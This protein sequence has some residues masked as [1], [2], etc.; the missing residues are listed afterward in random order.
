MASRVRSKQCCGQKWLL[1]LSPVLLL[2]VTISVLTMTLPTP[3][4]PADTDRRSSRA[5]S[6]AEDFPSRHW[7][8]ALH[9]VA[10]FQRSLTRINHGTW[11]P[12]AQ[13]DMSKHSVAHEPFGDAAASD[14]MSSRK[15]SPTDPHKSKHSS[16]ETASK[17]KRKGVSIQNPTSHHNPDPLE[18]TVKRNGPRHRIKPSNHSSVVKHT[19]QTYIHLERRKSTAG[20]SRALAHSSV[21]NRQP[22]DR[23]MDRWEQRDTIMHANT[24]IHDKETSVKSA[25]NHRDW[26]KHRQQS[27]LSDRKNKGQHAVKNPSRGLTKSDFPKDPPKVSRPRKASFKPVGVPKKDDSEQCLSYTAQDFLDSD[28]RRIRTG[29]DLQHTPWFSHD[30]IQKMVLLSEGE[31]ASK[32]KVPAH[33]QVLQLALN[34]P[35]HQQLPVK[36]TSQRGLDP[37]HPETHSELCQQ[38]RC[39]LIKRSEDWF[40]VFAYHLDRV[41]GLNRSLPVVLR[42]F[43][44]DILPYRYTNGIPRPVVWWD[45]DIKHLTETDNDQN[46]V[47]L[48]WEQYQKLLQLHCGKELDLRSAPCVGVNHSEW[49][50]LGLFDFLL[51]VSDRL[52]RCCCGF[53]PDPTDLCV[54]NLLHAKCGNTKDLLL[55]HILVR[56]ADPSKL[57]FIDNAG[58][59]QQPS[60]NLNFKLVEG[61]DEFPETAVSVLQSGC[62]ESLLLHSLYTDREFWHSQGGA[63][64]LLPVI[65]TVE[66]RGKILLQY[67]RDNKLQLQ[68]D[69]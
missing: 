3:L 49:G 25:Q 7:V 42:T 10:T 11:R 68:K 31:V 59:P 63:S 52:D 38:G 40:E 8:M 35:A 20:Q 64:G 4:P 28:N 17:R 66:Q 36:E 2:F 21:I 23:H 19:A 14:K 45:P 29:P 46:S 62:L 1:L 55:V 43:H 33:G 60:D 50:R 67:I 47:S 12:S 39:S 37:R 44:S 9:P 26:K 22:R 32:A 16:K 13:R 65:R 48:S 41:L 54:E 51:Q 30:D 18:F 6:S 53:K 24:Q 5:L 58:R 69:L 57:V 15:R 61:I 56:K 27:G 34:P